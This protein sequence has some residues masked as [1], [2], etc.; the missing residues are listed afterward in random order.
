MGFTDV[1]ERLGY[2]YQSPEAYDLID[3][4]VEF[5]SFHAIGASADL[6]REPGNEQDRPRRFGR[7]GISSIPGSAL[8]T[9]HNDSTVN[10]T[11]LLHQCRSAPLVRG[12]TASRCF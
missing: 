4:I 8:Q 3:E 10:Y 11:N 12:A 1:T 7:A 6:A 5:V 9:A 2:A